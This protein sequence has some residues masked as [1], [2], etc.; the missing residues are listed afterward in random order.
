MLTFNAFSCLAHL[1]QSEVFSS[2][3][4]MIYTGCTGSLTYN[5]IGIGI[6]AYLQKL[7]S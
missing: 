5:P 1:D 2:S 4:C 7:E 3:L 6:K